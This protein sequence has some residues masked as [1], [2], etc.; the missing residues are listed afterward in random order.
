MLFALD[1]RI[2]KSSVKIFDSA[3]SEVRLKNN[4]NYPW[5]ILIP[6]VDPLVTEIFELNENQ[7]IILSQEMTHCSRVMKK[8][9]QADKINV[10]ALG[11]MVSQLH[12]HIVARF[13]ND[14]VWPH[15]VWQSDVEESAYTMSEQMS[16]VESLR[17]AFCAS[18]K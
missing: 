17:R 15:S 10:G 14:G 4:K 5:I 3:L 11:N 1:E 12:I 13:K 6:R 8:Y 9:F 2:E 18:E 16:L 7:Q